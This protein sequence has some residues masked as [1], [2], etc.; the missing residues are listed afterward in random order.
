MRKNCWQKC[1]HVD[2]PGSLEGELN[3]GSFP[4]ETHAVARCK[5]F[6]GPA[7]S[8]GRPHP[9]R[10]SLFRSVVCGDSNCL[11]RAHSSAVADLRRCSTS[12][13]HSAVCYGREASFPFITMFPDGSRHHYCFRREDDVQPRHN[14]QSENAIRLLPCCTN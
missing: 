10:L 11:S 4:E 13:T 8:H 7:M 6:G 2:N 14:V 12:E 5:D 9:A 1:K 3:S